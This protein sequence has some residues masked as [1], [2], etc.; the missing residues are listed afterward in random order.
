MFG[1]R[2]LPA[3]PETHKRVEQDLKEREID[4]QELRYPLL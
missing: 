4:P 2:Y 1:Y 3:E